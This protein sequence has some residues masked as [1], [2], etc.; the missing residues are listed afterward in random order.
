MKRILVLCATAA[1]ALSAQT[2]TTLHT[3][4]SQGSGGHCPDGDDPEASLVQATNGDLYGTTLEGG[5]YNFGTVFKITPGGALT[6]LHSFCSQGLPD[7]PD[8]ASPSA[9]LVLATNG[10]L[11][12]TTATGGANVTGTVFKITPGG[13]LTTLYNFCSQS[14]CTDGANPTGGLIQAA[15]GN[16]YGTTYNRGAAGGGHGTV[17]KIAPSG[18]LT[19]LYAFTGG[20]D[21]GQPHGVIQASNG[22]FYGTTSS[23]GVGKSGTVFSITPSGTLTTLYSFGEQGDC[24]ESCSPSG[25]IE[26]TNGDL[27]GT[28]FYGGVYGDGM[29]FEITSSGTFTTLY[30]FCA[31]SDCPDGSQPE[32]GLVQATNGDFYGT[33]MSGGANNAGTVYSITPGG[34]LTTVYSFCAQSD[35]SDGEYPEAGLVQATNGDFYGTTT[36]GGHTDFGTIFSLSVGLGPFVETQTTSGK[37]GEVV[38]ILGNDLTGATGVAF[39]G[40]AAA[41]TV[42]SPALITATVPTGATTGTIQVVTPTGTLSSNVPFRVL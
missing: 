27:Y 13:A 38:G 35:C 42:V 24:S 22:D 10:D 32:P 4:C 30:S 6:R 36:F 19:T 8:G 23:G 41:F 9:A 18:T 5:A 40:T 11:Y 15:G 37:I 21:G 39:N 3:F 28:T 25:L 33:T 20:T 31:L 1:M 26:A 14:G 29:F 12:G 34:E 16:L 2:L 17:F 7:C